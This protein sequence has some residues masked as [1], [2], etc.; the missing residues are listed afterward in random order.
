MAMILA[1]SLP[2]VYRAMF[3][4][5]NVAINN[6]MACRVFRDIKFGHIS[7]T[8]TTLRTLPTFVAKSSGMGSGGT[9]RK[10]RGLDTVEL[11]M[12]DILQSGEIPIHENGIHVTK[13]I[14][15][16]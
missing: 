8:S 7:P 6:A 16:F 9:D 12:T 4:H 2:P 5:P 14:Q 13:S 11:R 1:P 10:R 15:Q 3:T